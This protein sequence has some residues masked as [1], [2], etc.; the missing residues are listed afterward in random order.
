MVGGVSGIDAR[1]VEGFKYQGAGG[2]RS[3]RNV[4]FKF[5]G[6]PIDL[7]GDWEPPADQ[8]SYERFLHQEGFNAL[9]QRSSVIY[10]ECIE[11][12]YQC[13]DGQPSRTVTTGYANGFLATVS[14]ASQNWVT[15]A[16]Y[17]RSGLW[18]T[19]GRG[20]GLV[21]TQA[22]DALAIARPAS[23]QASGSLAFW[24]SGA[25]SYDR[26]GNLTRL[27]GT[28]EGGNDLFLYDKV[29]RLKE[30]RIQV[31]TDRGDLLF[32]DGFESATSQRWLEAWPP[33]GWSPG[34][35]TQ[36]FTFDR[37][38]NLTKVE[39]TGQPTENFPTTE[40]TNRMTNA[41]AT[42]DSRGNLTTFND[43]TTSFTNSFDALNR[44]WKRLAP[45]GTHDYYLYTADD[46]RI[47][48]FSPSTA[49]SWHWILRDFGGK[50]LRNYEFI[51]S[52]PPA[53]VFVAAVKDYI[54]AGERVLGTED[55]RVP[56]DSAM[57]A[58][59]DHLGTPR[60]WTDAT[61]ND[62]R[63]LKYYPFGKEAT[64][65][66]QWNVAL[67]FT[68]HERDRNDLATAADDGDDLHTRLGA[69]PSGRLS[70]TDNAPGEEHRP[71]SWNRFA[72]VMGNPLKWVDPTG[73]RV[74]LALL[75]ALEREKLLEGLAQFTGNKYGVTK[76]LEL[77][78]VETGVDSSSAAT[79]YLNNLIGADRQF[80]VT[81]VDSSS[82]GISEAWWNSGESEVRINFGSFDKADYGKVD[83]RTFN[84]GSTFIHESFHASTGLRDLDHGILRVNSLDW[85]GPA[86]DFE[87]QIRGERSLPFRASYLTEP[88]GSGREKIR[89]DHVDPRRP[90]KIYYVTRPKI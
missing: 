76:D 4:T 11:F 14:D 25:H 84:L 18:N 45:D 66:D 58:T 33:S 90:S 17:H 74:S 68:G 89:F 22:Q 55:P 67:Q 64:P 27:V 35:K 59:V 51:N 83:R 72:Y 15:S 75:S 2:A 28:D 23:I 20:N 46:E 63:K 80:T 69:L 1:F 54:H 34:L 49:M 86:V 77:A 36:L 87:N 13:P 9:G 21:E 40:T 48:T 81:S 79:S 65:S 32:G 31:P 73:Q 8:P 37:F 85:T 78:L 26:S 43:G 82:K 24:T 39:T 60:L 53:A 3:E 6:A 44:Q 56:G 10:P 16:T 70:S 62:V 38:G 5:G 30:A 71:Q 7:P 42:Y 41:I 52:D 29:S 61:G 57:Y 50:V 88:G 19:M 47:L 12:T